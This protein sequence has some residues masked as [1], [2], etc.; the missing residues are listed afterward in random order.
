MKD[1]LIYDVSHELR[2]PITS[3]RLY[4]ELLKSAPPERQDRF[5]SVIM[6]Q[7][8]LLTKL[9]EDIL[10]LSRLTVSKTRKVA[11]EDTNLNVL[12][13]QS[14]MAHIPV[15]EDAGIRLIFE[16]DPALPLI[17]AE[18][19]QIARMVTNLVSNAFATP[20]KATYCCK[21]TAKRKGL[22]DRTGHRRR[23]RAARSAACVR[24]FL[25]WTKRT[26]IRYPRH[27]A[28]VSDRQGNR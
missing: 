5:L 16:P 25:S 6:E 9:V 1:M 13:D 27:R 21:L 10:D 17:R 14:F 20:L 4:S 19:S 8:A 24:A 22:F 15:A 23:D 18:Q 11:F 2:T 26:P 3:I 28:G 7:S 12:V